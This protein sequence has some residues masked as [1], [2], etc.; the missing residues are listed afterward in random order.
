MQLNKFT[1]TSFN[2]L[3]ITIIV[4][5]PNPHYH[6]HH[7]IISYTFH[8]VGCIFLQVQ[9]FSS[10]ITNMYIFIQTLIQLSNP[11]APTTL[12]QIQTTPH[13]HHVQPFSPPH[14]TQPYKLHPLSQPT[15]HKT[16]SPPQSTQKAPSI[17]IYTKTGYR[18][19]TEIGV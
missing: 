10:S 4:L 16:H 2:T 5:F 1:S 7:H 8:D 9:L 15:Q 17:Q 3:E 19:R 13:L 18:R 6:H 14:H 12:S 11:H